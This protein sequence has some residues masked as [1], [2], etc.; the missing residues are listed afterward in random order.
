M[1]DNVQNI[2]KEIESLG[3]N[4]W[5]THSDNEYEIVFNN[6]IFVSRHL[7][8][9]PQFYDSTMLGVLQKAL[10]YAKRNPIK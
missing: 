7:S 10:N 8:K 2:F 3:Y 5:L 6:E 9:L 1:D 4:W